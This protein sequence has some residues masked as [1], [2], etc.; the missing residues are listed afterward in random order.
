LSVKNKILLV[1]I[2]NHPEFSF[3][4]G[5]LEVINVAGAGK[6]K[7]EVVNPILQGGLDVIDLE[8][9]S[10]VI[11]SGSITPYCTKVAW[12]SEVA[13]FI[14]RVRS[15]RSL[16]L[17]AICMAHELVAHIYGGKVRPPGSKKELGTID[18]NLSDAGMKSD[19]FRG[20][21]KKFKMLAAHSRDVIQLPD[22]AIALVYNKRSKYQA[23]KL[24]NLFCV[25][26]H[27]EVDALTLRNWLLIHGSI[28]ELI[29]QKFINEPSELNHFLETEVYETRYRI[30]FF[31]NFIDMCVAEKL[32]SGHEYIK[33]TH[34]CRY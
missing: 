33:K 26:F 17:L 11:I 12:V 7:I 15:Y 24:D 10:G 8:K 31:R 27:A 28:D 9:Y 29:A 22:G 20:F 25:Q 5:F 2:L 3:L 1:D 34:V 19:L 13:D 32:H 23:F 4:D 30:D 6:V 14:N 18:L 21:P 16:P